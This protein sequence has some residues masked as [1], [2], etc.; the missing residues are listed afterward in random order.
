MSRRSRVLI[1]GIPLPLIQRGNNKSACFFNEQDYL[2]YLEILAE[3]ASKN[4]CDIHAW[5]LMTSHVHLLVSPHNAN[6]GGKWGQTTFR[7]HSENVVCPRYLSLDQLFLYG[8]SR[9]GL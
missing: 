7:K 8:A 6:S 9:G 1:P 4:Y 3:Q 5:C 2:F